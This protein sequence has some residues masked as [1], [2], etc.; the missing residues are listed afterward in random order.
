MF[1]TPTF[2]SIVQVS[3]KTGICSSEYVAD[4]IEERTPREIVQQMLK[5]FKPDTNA[6]I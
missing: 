4:T 2:I 6:A 5:Y 1:S 3:S